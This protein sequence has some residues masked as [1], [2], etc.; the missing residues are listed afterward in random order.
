MNEIAQTEKIIAEA[1]AALE[2]FVAPSA[3]TQV[4]YRRDVQRLMGDQVA[5]KAIRTSYRYR[6]AWVWFWKHQISQHL[7]EPDG[8][9]SPNDHPELVVAVEH[10]LRMLSITPPGGRQVAESLRQ[11]RSGPKTGLR[12]LQQKKRQ[13]LSILPA[14]W[15]EQMLERSLGSDVESALLVLAM[16]GCRPSELARGVIINFGE[17]KLNILIVGSKLGVD[18]G[19]PVRLQQFSVEDAW[20]ARLLETLALEHHAP[21]CYAFPAK[22]LARRIGRLAQEQFFVEGG[23]PSPLSFRHQFA[24]DLKKCGVSQ[25]QIAAALGHQSVRTQGMYG[26]RKNGHS[27]AGG[28]LLQSSAVRPIRGAKG[29]PAAEGG[30]SHIVSM[31]LNV[32]IESPAAALTSHSSNPA[33]PLRSGPGDKGGHKTITFRPF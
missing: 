11:D 24:A 29:V 33:V 14:Q 12:R 31:P 27:R 8:E 20:A 6:A 25:E 28:G 23:G 13:G 3:A 4:A 9:S 22:R 21:A 18:M 2:D 15:R 32:L 1:K 7:S 26:D 19:Q 16:T 30:L 10:A 17:Q 5:I